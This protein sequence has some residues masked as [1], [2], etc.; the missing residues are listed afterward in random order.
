MAGAV[1]RRCPPLQTKQEHETKVA[2]LITSQ[3]LI[4]R[5]GLATLTQLAGVGS[6]NAPEGRALDNE[7][8]CAAIKFASSLMT[9]Y[10]SKRYPA[11]TEQGASWTPE[12]LKGF[13]SDIAHYRLRSESGDRNLVTADIRQRYDDAIAWGKGVSRGLINMDIEGD[14]GA[15]E[16]TLTGNVQT[17]MQ[18]A[19]APDILKG[20]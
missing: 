8:I 15:T 11:A 4:A 7:K 20:Y 10:V 5:V 12:I 19:R 18:P 6:H 16:A 3:D 17:A 1:A 9:G 13:T 14:D 2:D